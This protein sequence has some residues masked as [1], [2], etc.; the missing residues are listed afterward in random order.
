[1]AMEDEEDFYLYDEL[2]TVTAAV[3]DLRAEVDDLRAELDRLKSA[4]DL[5]A[6]T[7][8]GHTDDGQSTPPARRYAE[9]WARVRSE[10]RET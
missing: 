8:L 3:A 2:A 7:V 4:G 5:L 1:M 10:K 9:N 6:A